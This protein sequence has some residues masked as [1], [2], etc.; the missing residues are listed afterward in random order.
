[1]HT[2]TFVKCC[3]VTVAVDWI[4]SKVILL[5]GTSAFH[6]PSTEAVGSELP[7]CSSPLGRNDFL[8]VTFGNGDGQRFHLP[9]CG[10]HQVDFILHQVPVF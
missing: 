5:D 10:G 8:C 1:M 6:S 4:L 7:K 9:Q 2:V 3:P